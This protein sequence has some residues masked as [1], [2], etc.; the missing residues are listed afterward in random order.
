MKKHSVGVEKSMEID[1][2]CKYEGT[3]SWC[4]KSMEISTKCKRLGY[5]IHFALCSEIECSAELNNYR[6]KYFFLQ[7]NVCFNSLF[8]NQFPLPGSNFRHQMPIP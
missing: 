2:K 7:L 5:V 6:K 1:T 4:R 8:T 3:H